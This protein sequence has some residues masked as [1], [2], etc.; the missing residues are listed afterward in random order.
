MNTLDEK[1]KQVAELLKNSKYPVA[2][3]GPGINAGSTNPV[4]EKLN[5]HLWTMLD[6]DDFTIHSYKDDQ[7]S[8]YKE[9]AVLF[10]ILAEAEP[11]KAHLA[12]AKLEK[13]GLIKA[14]ITQNVDGL[15][16][17]AGSRNVLEIRG[18]LRSASCTQCEHTATFEEII[19]GLEDDSSPPLC[20][21]C[22]QP[23]K[24][25]L[26]LADD[27]MPPDFYQAK[28]EAKKADLF[29]IIASNMRTSP[30]NQLPVECPNLVVINKDPTYFDEQ[31]KIVLKED[32]VKVMNL[33]LKGL[34][35]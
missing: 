22:G 2:L 30:D 9:G 14:I 6:P 23:L 33:L 17:Q 26:V 20:P 31:A 10:S 13:Q 16:Q 4:N 5:N 8:F 24:P 25:D 32:P 29:I 18:T 28:E 12:L 15:H 7:N 27:P 19:A 21:H 3:T 1:I 34:D 35:N 11:S